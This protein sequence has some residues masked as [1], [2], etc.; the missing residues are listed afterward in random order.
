[1]GRRREARATPH[2]RGKVFWCFVTAQVDKKEKKKEKHFFFEEKKQ[3]TFIYCHWHGVHTGELGANQNGKE[4]FGSFLQ[5]RTRL[6][7]ATE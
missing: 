1:L 4:F 5:K 3:K 7:S 2:Q 6:F